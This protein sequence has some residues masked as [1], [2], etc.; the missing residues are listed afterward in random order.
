MQNF[1]V[2]MITGQKHAKIFLGLIWGWTLATSQ[3][4]NEQKTSQNGVYHSQIII[5]T[6]WLIFLENQS[7][8]SKVTDAWKF[9]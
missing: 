4:K 9:A 8:I 2:K 7:K 5:S 6:F 3:S 1:S